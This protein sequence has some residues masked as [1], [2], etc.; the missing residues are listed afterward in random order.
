MSID[1]IGAAAETGARSVWLKAVMVRE[2]ND[3][4]TRCCV[5]TAGEFFPI[6]VR[7][8][9]PQLIATAKKLGI[10]VAMRDTVG[11]FGSWLKK[12]VKKV[13]KSKIVK[14]VGSVVKKAINSPIVQMAL[15]PVAIAKGAIKA[16]S[17]VVSF[18]KKPSF[19]ALGNIGLGALSFVSPQASAALGVGLQTVKAA[20]AGPAIASV[21]KTLQNQ[22]NLGKVAAN[23]INTRKAAAPAIAK[24][25]VQRAVKA[26]ATVQK[27]APTLA[28][29]SVQS[30]KV[31]TS[32]AN[33]AA[34]AKAGNKDAKLA[35]TVISKAAKAMNTVSQLEQK[36]VG[37]IA[38]LLVMPNGRIVR[39]PKGR[40][41]LRG[42]AAAKTAPTLYRGPNTPTL[43]GNFTAVSG[44]WAAVGHTSGWGGADDPGNGIDGPFGAVHYGTGPVMLDDYSRVAG[45]LTP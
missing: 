37:G 45:L 3:I 41:M 32:I 2:G 38:G 4:V 42:P 31:R 14:A 22:V 25:L 23:V 16:A 10:D 44:G 1:L 9:V 21:A 7:V 24:P 27:L 39:S 30:A 40:F 20:K 17:G 18:V 28:K 12:A 6:E 11:G 34:K 5:V 33:I 29:K 26:R 15:P 43:R 8:N 13:T 35:A 36:S 19:S